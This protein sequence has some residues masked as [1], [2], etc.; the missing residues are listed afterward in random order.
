MTRKISDGRVINAHAPLAQLAEHLTLNQGVRGSNPRW[1]T[2]KESLEF[3][4]FKDFLL[5][6]KQVFFMLFGPVL[7]GFSHPSGQKVDKILS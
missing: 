7:P 1:C 5:M 3:K 4:R 2:T 6:K